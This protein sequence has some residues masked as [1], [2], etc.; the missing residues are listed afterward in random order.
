MHLGAMLLEDSMPA[1]WEPTKADSV[2]GS[3]GTAQF[4]AKH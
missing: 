2:S 1:G 3:V 4:R